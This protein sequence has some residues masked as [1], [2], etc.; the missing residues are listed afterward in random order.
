[1]DGIKVDLHVH[2][3]K[4]EKGQLYITYGRYATDVMLDTVTRQ[5]QKHAP[6]CISYYSYDVR[7]LYRNDSVIW[8]LPDVT[9]P[10]RTEQRV[11]EWIRFSMTAS[12]QN[13]YATNTIHNINL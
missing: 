5:M 11:D 10:R 4:H 3:E 6:P 8:N 2:N 13:F 1:M 7:A 9:G 12:A